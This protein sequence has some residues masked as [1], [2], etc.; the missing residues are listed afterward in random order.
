M[1][2]EYKP[3][4]PFILTRTGAIIILVLRNHIR[5]VSCGKVDDT[6]YY[7]EVAIEKDDIEELIRILK[8]A[9]KL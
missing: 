6:P 3:L 2:L 5:L 9:L 7:S 8:Q 4:A 1:T